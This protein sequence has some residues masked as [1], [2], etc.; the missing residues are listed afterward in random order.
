ML[1][2]ET[3]PMPLD[4]DQTIHTVNGWRFAGLRRAILITGA[5]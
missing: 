4:I 3:K 2:S 5:A 1:V